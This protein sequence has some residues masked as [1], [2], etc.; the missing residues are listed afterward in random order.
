[1]PRAIKLNSSTAKY[2]SSFQSEPVHTSAFRDQ[3]YHFRILVPLLKH[4]VSSSSIIPR[5]L[6]VELRYALIALAAGG[7]SE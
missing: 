4:T 1:M 6:L 5:N 3:T 7:V 2:N